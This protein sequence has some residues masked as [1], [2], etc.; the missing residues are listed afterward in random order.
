M[1]LTDLDLDQS[2]VHGDYQVVLI[3][4]EM[5]LTRRFIDRVLKRPEFGRRLLSIVVD[6]AHVVSHWGA[7]F[8]KAYGRLGLIRAFVPRGTPVVALSATLPARI[9][10]DVLKRLEF[11]AS[12]DSFDVGNDRPNVSIIIRPIHHTLSSYLDLNFIIREDIVQAEDM[13]KTFL[14]ADNITTGTE[15]INHLTS[16]L[17]PLLQ[18]QGVIRPFNAALSKEY[19]REAMKQFL[20][21]TI[22]ILVCT[23]AAGMVSLLDRC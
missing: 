22:H 17:P 23:D 10:A 7:Q 11:G 9:R 15:I 2:I 16:L 8:R 5:A 21:G 4:P 19:R 3:S 14:Y 13:A 6:E 12:Y 20:S 1:W 18:E